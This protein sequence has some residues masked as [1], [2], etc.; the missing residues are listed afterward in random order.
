LILSPVFIGLM[1]EKSKR[2]RLV[3]LTAAA[4][5]AFLMFLLAV[6]LDLALGISA[7]WWFT[8]GLCALAAGTGLYVHLRFRSYSIVVASSLLTGFL[9]WLHFA[10]FSPVKP[11]RRF[12]AAIKPGM[13]ESGVL[14][15]MKKEF[16]EGGPNPAPSQNSY[17]P[18]G[19]TFGLKTSGKAWTGEAIVLEMSQGFVVSKRY[20]QD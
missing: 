15:A 6:A 4:I 16:P 13:T 19:L 9:I 14:D 17:R 11:F 12:F 7:S 3:V 8:A 2:G 1:V 5:S 10:D 18:N 20:I